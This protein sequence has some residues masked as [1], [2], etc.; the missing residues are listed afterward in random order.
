[1]SLKTKT[2][3]VRA[4]PE[5]Q[6][7]SSHYNVAAKRPALLREVSCGF[8]NFIQTNVGRA[9]HKLFHNR[10]LSPNF[11]LVKK[12]LNPASAHL[13]RRDCWLEP[14]PVAAQSKAWVCGR[15]LSG[16]VGSNSAGGMGISCECCV[17]SGRGFCNGTIP[18]PE[19]S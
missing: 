9:G 7:M 10:F 14:I 19:E 11:H 4:D 18:R 2:R 6:F 16:I 5:S 1:M 15:S 8:P 12:I 17:L 13:Q 3:W